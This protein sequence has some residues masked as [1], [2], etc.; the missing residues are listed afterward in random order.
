MQYLPW[1]LLLLVVAALVVMKFKPGLI[2]TGHSH[3]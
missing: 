1:V 3:E 2:P